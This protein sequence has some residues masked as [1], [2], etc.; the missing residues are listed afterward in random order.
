MPIFRI[1]LASLMVSLAIYT[2]MVGAAHGYDLV[3][4]YFADI[5]AMTWP[6]QFNSDFSCFLLLSG[7]WTAWRNDFSVTG[8][9][10]APVAT[11]GGALFLTAYLLILS[12]QTGGD[13]VAMLVGQRRAAAR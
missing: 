3:P 7:L 6:G 5:A 9:L 8:L 13:P 12:F 10:L 4:I 11:F 2:L 1:F